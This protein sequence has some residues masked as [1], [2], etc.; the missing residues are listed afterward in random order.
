[1]LFRYCECNNAIFHYGMK[2]QNGLPHFDDKNSLLIVASSAHAEFYKASNG[3]I[4]KIESFRVGKTEFRDEK[5]YFANP[6]KSPGG[7]SYKQAA[8]KGNQLVKQDTL[9]RFVKRFKSYIEKIRRQNDFDEVYIFAPEYFLNEVQKLVPAS[10]KKKEAMIFKGNFGRASSFEL[11]KKIS[12][13]SHPHR[14]VSP[15]KVT[16][17][18][19]SN[20]IIR[21][22]LQAKKV[23]RTKRK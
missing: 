1:M 16:R 8:G 14:K 17:T 7:R 10:L 22:S 2:I 13:R 21:K 6:S 18:K 5:S 3:K 4:S 11:L 20:N 9:Q 23:M 12:T 19:E 15:E